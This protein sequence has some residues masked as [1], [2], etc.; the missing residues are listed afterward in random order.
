MTDETLTSYRAAAD[1]WERYLATQPEA[2][3]RRRRVADAQ[4][5]TRAIAGIDPTHARARRRPGVQGGA[6]RRRGAP[7]PRHL[8]PRSPPTPS[9]PVT[10]R[11]VPRPSRRRS[12][13]L[14]IR[15]PRTRSRPR[16]SRLKQQGAAI[17]KALKQSAPDQSQLQ[18]PLGGSRRHRSPRSR[19]AR[20]RPER[21]P[22]AAPAAS[23]SLPSPARAI[24]SV[25]RAGDS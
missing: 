15:P 7:E 19:A 13:R 18:D 9:S 21:V 14:P 11:P 25:G 20:A 5:P 17:D 24:S 23:L 3:R 12:R 2:T 10:T 22:A 16:S 8:H 4:R 6:G 1:A